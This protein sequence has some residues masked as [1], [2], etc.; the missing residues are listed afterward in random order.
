[1]TD[2]TVLH[3]FIDGGDPDNVA[4][5]VRQLDAGVRKKLAES[6][7]AYEKEQR[8]GAFVSKRFWAPRMCAMTV[9]GAALLPSASSVAVWIARN[10]MREDETGTDVIDLVI[11]V[12]LDRRV[13]WLPDLVDRLALRLPSDR[14]DPDMQQLVTGLAAHTGIAPLATDGLVYAWI[15]TGHADTSRSS[16]AR[17]LFEVDGLGPLLEAGDWPRKLADDQSLD[18]AMLLEGCL[19]RLRRGGKAADLNGF[20][21][22]HKALAPTREEVAKLAEDYEALLAGAHAP[23]AAMARHELL[24][25]SQNA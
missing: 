8:T 7:R 22:L 16:L 18:R 20:L 19:Y 10:G 14:L 23:T 5:Q 13:T 9:A 4:R 24:L 12:L 1:M 6:L 2:W 25:A 17:R 3:P 15:A 21:L 11:E